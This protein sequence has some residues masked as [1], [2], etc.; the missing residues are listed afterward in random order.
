VISEEFLAAAL[1]TA[2]DFDVDAAAFAP[3]GTFLF[4]LD[5]AVATTSSRIAAANGGARTLADETVFSIAPG[6]S[7]AEVLFRDVDA[8]AMVNRALETDLASIVDVQGLEV[9][10]GEVLFTTGLGSGPG[11]GAVFSARAGG[12]VAVLDGV[13]LDGDA[14]G[15]A[16]R[17]DWNGLAVTSAPVRAIVLDT[18]EPDVYRDLNDEVRV[19]VAAGTPFGTVRLLASVLPR[20]LR[21][22]V[23]DAS[24]EGTGY[25][26]VERS[27]PMYARSLTSP[28]TLLRLDERGDATA[29]FRLR[30]TTPVMALG[31]QA[32]DE[33]TRV[34]SHAIVVEIR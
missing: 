18:P 26:F 3:D 15:L 9:V 1:E 17:V 24:L 16:E 21:A 6:A 12:E 31:L 29:S 32:V 30:G 7:R 28:R 8:I 11:A 5:G 19:R 34:A 25:V 33:T 2:F 10:D 22:P 27:S 4:S 14:F 23:A 20:P 13:P